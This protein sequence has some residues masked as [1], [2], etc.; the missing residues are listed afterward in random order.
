M[1][2]RLNGVRVESIFIIHDRIVRRADG[3][4]QPFMGLSTWYDKVKERPQTFKYLSFTHLQVEIEVVDIGDTFVHHCSGERIP[5]LGGMFR[6]SRRE[7]SVVAL[8]AHNYRQAGAICTRLIP[9]V[10]PVERC[11]DLR[12]FLFEDK[13]VLSLIRFELAKT[14]KGCESFDKQRFT[15]DT[16]SR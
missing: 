5:I 9:G 12:Q 13:L 1:N 14:N 2:A 7:A 3:A 16:P 15:S 10:E 4:L 11:Q 8:P 6:R